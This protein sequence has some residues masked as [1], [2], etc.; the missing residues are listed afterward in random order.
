METTTYKGEKLAHLRGLC[1]RLLANRKLV[2]ASNRGPLEHRPTSEG[3]VEARRGSGGVVTALN[4]LTRMVEFGWVASAMG[5]G[6]RAVSR[7]QGG[8]H[9]RSPLPGHRIYVRYVVTP[10]RV[11]HKYYNVLC[12]PLLWFL[13]HYMWNSPYNPNV[14]A[15]VMDAWHDGYV[16]VNRA[17]ADAIVEEASGGE[18]APVIMIHDY[19]LYLTPGNVREAIPEAAIT[20]FVHIPWPGPRYWQLLPASMRHAI[21]RSL[22]AADIVG[23]QSPVDVRNFVDTCEAFLPEAEVDHVSLAVSLEGRRTVAR[24]YPVSIDVEEVRRIAT[25]RRALEYEKSIEALCAETT[26]VRVDRAEPSKNV[27]R[28]FRA[29]SIF[30]ARHPEL[31]GR[32]TFLAFLVPSRTHIRQYK[33]YLSEI[34]TVVGEIN[35]RFGK[36]DWQPVTVFYENNYTQAIAGMKQYDVLLVNPVIDGMNLVAKEGPVVNTKNGVLVLSETT[37]SYRQLREGALGVAPADLEGTA[38]AL[39]QAITMEADERVRRANLLVEAVQREDITH[40]ICRQ[41]EDIEALA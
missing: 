16:P 32:V 39:H 30:L 22:C 25:S 20:F 4:S 8:K 15:N 9:V 34:E 19:H 41:L 33:R 7:G 18:E 23:F 12:N 28:G 5:E 6:D 35:M 3:R 1:D 11:Y 37:G 17:F 29:Y 31:H 21:C 27:V 14:D 10:R 36:A 26:I 13:Q 2:L 24:A 40:W 38:E